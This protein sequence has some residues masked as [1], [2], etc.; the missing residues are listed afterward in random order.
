MITKDFPYLETNEI[1]KEKET[2]HRIHINPQA[3]NPSLS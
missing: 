2:T 1:T 3:E